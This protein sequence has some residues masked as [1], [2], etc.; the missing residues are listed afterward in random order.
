L[1]SGFSADHVDAALA[2]TAQVWPPW[3][4]L[5]DTAA[6]AIRSAAVTR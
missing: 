3:L 5:L 1:L 6:G 4:E 2:Q